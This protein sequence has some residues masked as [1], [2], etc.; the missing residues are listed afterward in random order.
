[1][2][3]G[4]QIDY[5]LGSWFSLIRLSL[6]RAQQWEPITEKVEHKVRLFSVIR[7]LRWSYQSF[8]ERYG[9]TYGA[10]PVIWSFCVAI[11]DRSENSLFCGENFV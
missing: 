3:R 9:S 10:A 6:V 5:V 1:M 2:Y 11:A 7:P 8:F 4:A